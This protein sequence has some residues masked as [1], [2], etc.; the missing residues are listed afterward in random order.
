MTRREIGDSVSLLETLRFHIEELNAERGEQL[1][2]IAGRIRCKLAKRGNVSGLLPI[3]ATLYEGGLDFRYELINFLCRI[4]QLRIYDKLPSNGGIFNEGTI[5]FH[6]GSWSE[7]T[8]DGVGYFW[9]NNLRPKPPSV[10]D[11]GGDDT[12]FE[13]EKLMHRAITEAEVIY[14]AKIKEMEVCDG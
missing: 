13:Q 1:R 10:N 12:T 4:A 2:I 3:H 14:N 9:R 5:W 6:D 8:Y 7:F 11:L